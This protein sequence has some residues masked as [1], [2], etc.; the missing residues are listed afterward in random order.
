[1]RKL[2]FNSIPELNSPNDAYYLDRNE[3]I[4]VLEFV[5]EYA[6]SLPEGWHIRYYKRDGKELMT[7]KTCKD[8][9]HDC[10]L[11]CD[12][13]NT[14]ENKGVFALLDPVNRYDYFEYALVP[15]K[16]ILLGLF[17]QRNDISNVY[18]VYNTLETAVT[19]GSSIGGNVFRNKHDALLYYNELKDK[20]C[21]KLDSIMSG[22]ENL[23]AMIKNA[24]LMLNNLP[25]ISSIYA[26]QAKRGEK[27]HVFYSH[28]RKYSDESFIVD[29]VDY[30]GVAHLKNGKV[31]G[32]D[33]LLMSDEFYCKQ[34][35]FTI[36]H[37]LRSNIEEIKMLSR[38][39][40]AFDRNV[41]PFTGKYNGIN[42]MYLEA[43]YKGLRESINDI[44]KSL[45]KE[46]RD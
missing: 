34:G 21:S 14:Y 2:N 5:G 8:F 41:E 26:K 44:I 4:G 32:P 37:E 28:E 12:R 18:H 46:L 13:G 42:W 9:N 22:L 40:N 35:L 3:N 36:R 27:Y 10:I 45:N 30:D 11:F 16:E 15:N 6:G 23:K 33:E 39:I 17:N 43:K 31:F 24:L 19:M 29:H 7:I 20:V 25:T 1:M 38:H